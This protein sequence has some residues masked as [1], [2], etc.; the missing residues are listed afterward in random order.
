MDRREPIIWYHNPLPG[1]QAGVRRLLEEKDADLYLFL[2][3]RHME[4]RHVWSELQVILDSNERETHL[5]S[6]HLHS[7]TRVATDA[8]WREMIVSIVAFRDQDDKR[9]AT[10]FALAKVPTKQDTYELSSAIQRFALIVKPLL[11]VRHNHLAH[12]NRKGIT[13][14]SVTRVE[15][16]RIDV[17][18]D[19]IQ[20]ALIAFSMLHAL[21]M[22]PLHSGPVPK[23]GCRSLLHVLA[24]YEKEFGYKEDGT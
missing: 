9:Q 11:H 14:R 7:F 13:Q 15:R 6:K 21:P 17:A 12:Y 5:L 3:E 4:L 10:L 19:A 18:M 1:F 16:E 24:M 8:M 23:G 22:A 20:V 2:W